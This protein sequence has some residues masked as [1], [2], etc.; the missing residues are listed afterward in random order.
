MK[1]IKKYGEKYFSLITNQLYDTA[2]EAQKA[3]DRA[4]LRVQL[5]EENIHRS[6]EWLFLP[7]LQEEWLAQKRG[8]LILLLKKISVPLKDRGIRVIPHDSA[9]FYGPSQI[10][11]MAEL[12]DLV[13]NDCS[14]IA[15]T[16]NNLGNDVFYIKPEGEEPKRYTKFYHEFA[17]IQITK[18]VAE[19][20]KFQTNIPFDWEK[21]E[22]MEKFFSGAKVTDASQTTFGNTGESTLELTHPEFHN[23]QAIGIK[24]N[25][26]RSFLKKYCANYNSSGKEEY[27][28]FSHFLC[29]ETLPDFKL[30]K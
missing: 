8:D 20:N 14:F 22:K 16:L 28:S 17:E 6:W 27:V 5:G 26:S 23:N 12:L 1:N 3:S 2:D 30:W 10:E 13:G 7:F 24:G 29:Q 9:G 11:M 21:L 19:E 25:V 15:Q 4:I 18:L